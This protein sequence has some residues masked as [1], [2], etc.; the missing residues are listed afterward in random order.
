M[1]AAVGAAQEVAEEIG[2]LSGLARAELRQ[3]WREM[4][5]SEPPNLSRDLL[6]RALTHAMQQRRLGGLAK[7]AERMLRGEGG[8]A[9]RAAAPTPGTRFVRAWRGE[10]QVVTV[11]PD[12]AV[13]WREQRYASLSAVAR[14]ITGTRWSGPAFFGVKRAA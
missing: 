14:A 2:R 10:A 1:S 5:R 3:A 4:L 8:A 7:E 9:M 12:G 6:L 13:L 11:A